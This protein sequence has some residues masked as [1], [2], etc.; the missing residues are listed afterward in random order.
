MSTLLG[1]AAAVV[2]MALTLTTTPADAGF[3]RHPA[4]W[5]SE[6]TVTHYGY[7]PRYHHVYRTHSVTDPYAYRY[8]P[9]G[10]YPYYNSGYWKPAHTMRC[11]K[12]RHY[13]QPPYYQAWGY[14]DRA[15]HHRA[16]HA[17][18]HGYI[19]RDHW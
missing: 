5:G 2:G 11:R 19:R 1:L 6:R 10:Y 17:R 4:G 9:R 3:R 12:H 16:W 8:E 15:Y 18:H 14:E 7:Y 13:H